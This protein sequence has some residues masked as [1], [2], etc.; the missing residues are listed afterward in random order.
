[1]LVLSRKLGEQVVVP[2][3]ELTVTIVAVDGN[4]VRLGFTAPKAVGVYRQEVLDR[5][6]HSVS[7]SSAK[8]IP[9]QRGHS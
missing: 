5:I 6:L 7:S 2:E 9:A 1:M 4:N 8:K 3:C